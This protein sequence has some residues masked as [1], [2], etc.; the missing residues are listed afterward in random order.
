V[1]MVKRPRGADR[2]QRGGQRAARFA[3]CSQGLSNPGCRTSDRGCGPIVAAL[4]GVSPQPHGGDR[5]VWV[6]REID[7]WIA[8]LPN[9][10]LKGDAS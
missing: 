7:A 4:R 8:A 10:Q 5:T 1:R 6:E 9:R 3:C 2:R